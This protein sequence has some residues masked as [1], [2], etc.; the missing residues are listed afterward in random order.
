[1]IINK[2]YKFKVSLSKESFV[3]K[4]ISGAMIGSSKVADN[5]EI[6]KQYGFNANKGISYYE[7]ELNAE[8]LTEKLITGHVFCHLFNPESRRKDNTFNSSQKTN[9]NFVGSFVI[10]VDIDYTNY[11]NVE[12][13]VNKLSLKPTLYYTSYSNL[14][15]GKGARFRLIYVFDK[16]IKNFISFRYA[17]WKLNQIIINDVNEEID[18]TCN[19]R[20][21]QYFNGTNINNKNLIVSYNC[22]NI[23]YSLSDL[24]LNKEEYIDFLKHNCYYKTNTHKVIINSILNKLLPTTYYNEMQNDTSE[25]EDNINQSVSLY[26][27]RLL[28]DMCRLDYDEFMKYNR[29]KYPY[30][31]RVEKDIW[32]NNLYQYVDEGY[33]AF[34]Y[35]YGKNAILHDGQHRRKKL[36]MRMCLRRVMRPNVDANTILFNAYEDIHRF[37]DFSGL[38]M[39]DFLKRNIEYCFAKTIE[40]IETEYSE[41]LEKLR[42]TTRPKRGIIYKNK[43]AY[44][45]E[46]TYLILDEYYDKDLSVKDNISNLQNNFGLNFKERTIYYY[47][48]NR[49]IKSDSRKIS[50]NE[51]LRMINPNLNAKE[52]FEILKNSDVKIGNKRFNKLYK[53][54]MN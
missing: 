29:H 5:K 23:I 41:V 47:I 51:V 27:E 52:N 44:S 38:D 11:K 40:E 13:Y 22:S 45:K 18:D 54:Y 12:E 9:N 15:E 53:Q 37:F 32:E 6:R 1:M 28:N 30:F 16:M 25:V 43:K 20:C 17:A 2:N 4:I 34:P 7:V 3:D 19:L 42:N 50:D 10:G 21:S 14:Q 36:F 35:S 48:Q 39:E 26:D 8:E 33:F 24:G 49:N 31:Y 46:T